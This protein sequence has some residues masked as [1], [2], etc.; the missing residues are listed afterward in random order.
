MCVCVLLF[1]DFTTLT[2][3]L[4]DVTETR[5]TRLL[6]GLKHIIWTQHHLK[7]QTLNAP[8]KKKNK[9]GVSFI[10]GMT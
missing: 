2:D 8:K 9:L 10:H 6:P 5:T 3:S 7:D 1:S 4:T